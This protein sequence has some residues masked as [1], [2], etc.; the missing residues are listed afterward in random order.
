MPKKQVVR[1]LVIDITT[2]TKNT[3]K[4]E[5]FCLVPAWRFPTAVMRNKIKRWCREVWRASEF[6]KKATCTTTVRVKNNKPSFAEIKNDFTAA[7]K[8]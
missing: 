7:E 6:S 3:G 2:E 8:H 5:L 1:G 4:P